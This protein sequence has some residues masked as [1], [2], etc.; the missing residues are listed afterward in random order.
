MLRIREESDLPFLRVLDA[1]IRGSMLTG[2]A[3]SDIEKMRFLDT[4]FTL[5]HRHFLTCH[6][7][8]DFLVI[9]QRGRS[10]GR[11]YID[12][13]RSFWRIVDIAIEP[14]RQRQ[15]LGRALLQ[16][17]QRAARRAR[18]DGVDLHVAHDNPGAA[19]LY[20]ALGFVDAISTFPTHRRMTWHI[21]QPE[22]RAAA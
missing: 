12:R 3:W 4:Q 7:A 6:G 16:W 22:P 20:A 18:V 1:A 9:R 13:A 11:L 19:R 5:Q 10:I 8:A 2:V 15:G 17:I 14:S 21:S